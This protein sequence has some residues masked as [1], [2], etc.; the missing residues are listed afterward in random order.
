M[1][2][3]AEQGWWDVLPE[4]S[5]RAVLERGYGVR[6]QGAQ[7][8]QG[9]QAA[10]AAQ[11]AQGAQGSEESPYDAERRA[12]EGVFGDRRQVHVALSSVVSRSVV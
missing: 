7:G 6:A 10:Q 9:A 12:F 3:E 11:A 1:S 2:L 8:A 5:M 4:A